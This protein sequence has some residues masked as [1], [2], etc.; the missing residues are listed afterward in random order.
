[1]ALISKFAQSPQLFQCWKS[2]SNIFLK[3]EIHD[4][5]PAVFWQFESRKEHYQ[6]INFPLKFLSFFSILSLIEEEWN[7]QERDM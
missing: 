7:I 1:M 3:K 4:S 5:S 2:S 6:R